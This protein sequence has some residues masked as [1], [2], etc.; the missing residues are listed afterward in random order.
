MTDSET[1]DLISLG[2][3][4]SGELELDPEPVAVGEMVPAC[5]DRH[6]TRAEANGLTR[7]RGAIGKSGWWSAR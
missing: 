6:R 2:R 1:L 7:S 4:E 3:V 5:L